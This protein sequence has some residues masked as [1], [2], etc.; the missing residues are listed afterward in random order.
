MQIHEKALTLNDLANRYAVK[1]R[2]TK[3]ID[4]YRQALA[5]YIFLA[6][7]EPVN[8]GIHIAHVFSNLS[9]IYFQLG[10]KMEADELHQNALK[11]HRVLAKNNPLKYCIELAR[12]LV[13]GVLYLGEHPIALYE[14]ELAIL[15]IEEEVGAKELIA[16]IQ[17]LRPN[18]AS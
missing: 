18:S 5:Y 2:Y 13:D 16:L 4:H 12:C 1:M 6:K 11:M 9:I 3:A 17:K 7:S 10:K 14:A 15:Q 8:Y